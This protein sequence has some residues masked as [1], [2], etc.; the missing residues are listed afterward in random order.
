VRRAQTARRLFTGSYEDL[1]EHVKL[2]HDEAAYQ[3]CDGFSVSTGYY[4]IYPHVAGIFD[5]T[6][7]RVTPEKHP[8]DFRFRILAPLHDLTDHIE[9]YVEG[10]VDAGAFIEEFLDMK[11]GWSTSGRQKTGS[12]SCRATRSRSPENRPKSASSSPRRGAP[13]SNKG[14]GSV[15]GERPAED[16]RDYS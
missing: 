1:V 15:C 9:V 12:S 13:P 16:H 4:A 10:L 6:R 7:E 14:N 8:V 5:K 11:T 3:L 2:Y